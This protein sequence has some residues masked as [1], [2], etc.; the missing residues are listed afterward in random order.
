M[1]YKCFWYYGW[2]NQ[3]VSQGGIYFELRFDSIDN[4]RTYFGVIGDT[5]V[6][7]KCVI[8]TQVVILSQSK[9]CFQV[10]PRG[11]FYY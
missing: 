6:N 5:G 9:V 10:T 1:F 3:I 11:Y 2:I 8:Q 4:V 7:N